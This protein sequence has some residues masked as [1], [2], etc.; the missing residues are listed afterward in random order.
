MLEYINQDAVIKQ[1]L[2]FYKFLLEKKINEFDFTVLK[3]FDKE[4]DFDYASIIIWIGV[5]KEIWKIADD[6]KIILNAE[7]R[8]I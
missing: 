8:K 3:E 5:G 2:D 4:I 1:T 6:Y 7:K